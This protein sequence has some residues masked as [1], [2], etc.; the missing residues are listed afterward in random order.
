MMQRSRM[1]K[2]I[3]GVV[4]IMAVISLISQFGGE[5]SHEGEA[6]IPKSASELKGDDYLEVSALFEESGFTRIKPEKIDDLVLG[7][8]TKDGE[9]EAVTVGGNNSFSA[10]EWVPSD[11]E[12]IIVYHTFPKKKQ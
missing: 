9:V 1:K 11:T 12:V 8:L 6:M 10:G 7:L 4:I 3:L 2:I 5:S